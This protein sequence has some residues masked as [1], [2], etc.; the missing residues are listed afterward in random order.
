MDEFQELKD[1]VLHLA[2][3]I[4]KNRWIGIVIAWMILI[5]GILAVDRIQDRYE[6][7]TKVFIDTDSVLRP[8]LKGLAIEPDFQATVRLISRQLLSRPNVERAI[9]LMD[10]SAVSIM[11]PTPAVLM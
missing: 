7:E 10:K 9:R 4:W 3:G 2:R 5:G 1:L 8:L 11:V 6:A